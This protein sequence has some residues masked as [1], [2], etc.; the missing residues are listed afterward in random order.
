MW[1]AFSLITLV[2][3]PGRGQGAAWVPRLSNA[4][5]QMAQ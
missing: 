1:F 5:G 3:R 4:H 2:W